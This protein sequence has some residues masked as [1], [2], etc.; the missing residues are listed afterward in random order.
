MTTVTSD[1]VIVVDDRF[2]LSGEGDG[3]HG[4]GLD[5]HTAPDAAL[6]YDVRFGGY[7]VF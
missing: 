4:T 7:T 3:I 1:A 2:V 6:A 5:A